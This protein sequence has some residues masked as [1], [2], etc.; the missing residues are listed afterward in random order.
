MQFFPADIANAAN[1]F[2]SQSSSAQAVS[3]ENSGDSGVYS[4]GSATGNTRTFAEIFDNNLQ[5]YNA[6]NTPGLP[7]GFRSVRDDGSQIKS[8]DLNNLKDILTDNG[9]DSGTVDKFFS[10]FNALFAGISVGNLQGTVSSMLGRKS[11][12]L[13][14]QEDIALSALLLK[15]GFDKDEL[16][17]IEDMA[18]QGRGDKLLDAV[19]EKISKGAFQFNTDEAALLCRAADLDGALSQQ[20]LAMFNGKYEMELNADSFN[21]LFGSAQAEL[22]NARAA[23]TQLRDALP[24]AINEMF[25]LRRQEKNAPS[26]DNRSS[27]L[28][29]RAA[30]FAAELATSLEDEDKDQKGNK[31]IHRKSAAAHLLD[32]DAEQAVADAVAKTRHGKIASAKVDQQA[33]HNVEAKSEA[34][35]N[36]KSIFNNE[37]TAAQ[38]NAD[39]NAKAS[40]AKD[41][42]AEYGKAANAEAKAAAETEN[43]MPF[44]ENQGGS[45][46]ETGRNDSRNNTSDQKNILA[47]KLENITGPYFSAPGFET[48][49]SAASRQ[50]TKAAYEF[51]EKV[52][53]Q[54]EKGLVRSLADGAKQ[55]VLRLD[56][57]ELGKLTLSL[58]MAQG[59]VKAV[60]RTESAATTQV[61]SEQLAQLKQ[62]LEEQGFKVSS[63]EV[64]TR[65]NQHAGTDNWNGTE[66]HNK[67]QEL[68]EKS[69]F[70]RLA[71]S[72]NTEG[73]TLARSM[74]HMEQSASISAAGLHIIA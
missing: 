71:R 70:V 64:E 59:E 14:E 8:D 9:V 69:R 37:S 17:Q 4:Y 60:I 28:S 18:F 30:I 62:T 72:R 27:R 61:I 46:R 20:L 50:Q 48:E 24:G 54:V 32:A 29:E 5:E 33:E 52:F 40:S 31:I 45:Q 51:Q 1:I 66:Q 26:A 39:T 25:A 38:A 49:N 73:D 41:N 6:E 34:A 44:G 15:M 7:F 65:T 42:M 68:Q 63:L 36:R 11:S 2:G 19:K 74:Q 21:K 10:H 13:N 16:A 35:I 47:S 55:M 53:E 57:P 23:L 43:K 58:T 67:Q 56:P 3:Y 22:K 12:Q